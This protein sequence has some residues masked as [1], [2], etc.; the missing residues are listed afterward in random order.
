MATLLKL[1][2]FKQRYPQI[3]QGLFI[4]LNGKQAP[5]GQDELNL[6]KSLSNAMWQIPK[7]ERPEMA[8]KTIAE[9]ISPYQAVT[10][11]HYEAKEIDIA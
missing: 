3:W 9:L 5:K 2:E 11:T 1:L 10:L 8:A 4:A 6:G 7:E